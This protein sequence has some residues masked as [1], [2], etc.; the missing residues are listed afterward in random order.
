MVGAVRSP[1]SRSSVDLPQ[2][3]GPIS[4]TNSPGADGQ[5]DRLERVTVR[6]AVPNTLPTPDVGRRAPSSARGSGRPAPSCADGS[7]SDRWSAALHR[8]V[9][10]AHHDGLGDVDEAE[11]EQA[12]QC[13]SRSSPTAFRPGDVVLVVV[14]DR[15][16]EAG[17]SP[18]VCSPMIAPM[19]DGRGADAER[20]EQVRHRRRQA[21]LPEDLAARG[22]VRAEQLERARDRP[23]AGRAA[24]R[25]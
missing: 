9:P 7:A 11:E 10:A 18:A 13:T 22:G 14:E 12:Q 8:P 4:D 19:I 24:T 6:G 23:R 2:P 5:V 17:A 1:I 15:A 21:Q 16:A 20:G 25:S 3:D